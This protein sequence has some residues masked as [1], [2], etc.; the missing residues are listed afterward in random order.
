MNLMEQIDGRF[1]LQ[2]LDQAPNRRC[3]IPQK[4]RYWILTPQQKFWIAST[5]HYKTQKLRSGII[6]SSL[7]RGSGVLK[8][9]FSPIF[10][11]HRKELGVMEGDI[12]RSFNLSCAL[13]RNSVRLLPPD[14]RSRRRVWCPT[15]GVFEADASKT[16]T[17]SD[18]GALCVDIAI[19]PN[20]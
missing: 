7:N 10:A 11:H 18:R 16:L 3:N 17:H 8:I 15:L 12:S 4:P 6:A 13:R 1:G 5:T 20:L 2:P 14:R 9:T 19:A